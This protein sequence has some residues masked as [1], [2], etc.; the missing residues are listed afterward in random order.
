VSFADPTESEPAE[1][2]WFV[3]DASD[4]DPLKTDWIDPES[5]GSDPVGP[6]AAETVP[7]EREPDRTDVPSAAASSETMVRMNLLFTATSLS[8]LLVTV[9]RFS[10][11]TEIVL[12]PFHFLRLHEVVQMTVLILLTVVIQVL[13]LHTITRRF[14]TLA[15]LPLLAFVV[16]VYFF[17]TG[18]GVHELGSF[19]LQAYCHPDAVRGSDKLCDGLFFNDFYTGNSMF[20]FGALVTTSALLSLEQCSPLGVGMSRKATVVL[21]INAVVYAFAVVA[22]A[23]FDTVLVGLAFTLVMAAV[24][25]RSLAVVRW[26]YRKHPFIT[27]TTLTY[28]LG[29]AAG[30][31]V[32]LL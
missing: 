10:V 7:V 19:T 16:G 2:H 26:Q 8:V 4:F 13:L 3:S 23:G 21:V 29:G 22:Y 28:V 17:A 25:L 24:A 27:Y 11:T 31:A 18:N 1:S 6:E 5:A 32:R 14:R 9:E 30:V 20:F 12:P 15:L